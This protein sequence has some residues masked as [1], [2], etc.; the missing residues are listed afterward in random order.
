MSCVFTTG[1][2]DGGSDD[3][4]DPAALP[5][6]G[7]WIFDV[8]PSVS[9]VLPADDL[10]HSTSPVVIVFSES[11]AQSTLA[12]AVELVPIFNG[13]PGTALPGVAQALVGDGRV[14]VLL[15]T[16]LAPADYEVRLSTSAVVT[17]LTGQR[18]VEAPGALLS[19]FTVPATAPTE[20]RVVATWPVDAATAQSTT[21][22]VVVVLDRA[23][24]A[25]SVDDSSFIV[26]VNGADPAADPTAEALVVTVAGI[27]ISD[28]RVYLWR[29]E[30]DEGVPVSLGT[31]ASVELTLS[32]PGSEIVDAT[33][34]ALPETSISFTTLSLAAPL[35]AAFLSTP[36]DGI[37]IRNLTAGDAEE[38]LVQVE[39]DAAAEGDRL[40]LFLVGSSVASPD[41]PSQLVALLRTLTL[42]GTSPIVTADFTL[43]DIDL[44]RTT[45]PA[46][47][48]RFEDGGVAFA[49]R[50]RRGSLVT[51]LAVLDA[52]PGAEGIQDPTLD[53]VAPTLISYL[54]PS[55]ST[56]EAR[57]AVRDMVIAGRASEFLRSVEVSSS[58]GTNGTLPPVIGSD[59]TGSFVAFPIVA[60]VLPPGAVDFSIIGYDAALNASAPQDG[61]FTQLGAVGSGALNP[62]G[63]IMVQVFDAESLELLAGAHVL[64]HAD[65]GDGTSFP[66]LDEAATD[67]L[68]EASL[69]GH[70]PTQA[71]TLL[72]VELSGY[73][74][75]T[76]HGVPATRVSVPL[77]RQ[78][79]GADASVSGTLTTE[80]AIAQLT[81][82][83]GLDRKLDD[84]R[85][86]EET[87][88]TYDG[89]TCSG[90]PLGGSFACP[91]G[92]EPIRI[93]VLGVQSFLAGSLNQAEGS[94]SAAILLQAFDLQIPVPVAD[95]GAATLTSIEL[96]GLFGEPGLF[97]EEDQPFAL[98][99]AE[100]LVD[101]SGG[102]DF[103]NLDDDPDSTGTPRVSVETIVPG[104]PGTV[105]V[106]L[107]LAFE[108]VP[109][110]PF[111][112]VKSAVPGAVGIDGFF[113]LNGLVDTDFRV[114]ME[115]RDGD[116][117]RAGVRVRRSALASHAAPNLPELLSP[118]SGGNSL[119]TSYSVVFENTILDGAGEPGLYEVVL[120][121][122]VGRRWH[123]WRGD[124]VDGGDLSVRVPDLGGTAAIGLASGATSCTIA[125][126]AWQSLSPSEFLWSDIER[127]HDL[128]AATKSVSFTVP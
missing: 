3:L 40:D 106:G 36:S 98:E 54:H 97:A 62:G 45:D 68:G 73:D 74:L 9:E 93:G 82:L 128:F 2:L 103:A 44:L 23:A 52:D 46:L 33:G 126:F 85:R 7:Q 29:S 26:Q 41:V 35:A 72:S 5:E 91:Y 24:A 114:R 15:P 81:F 99:D 63:V 71:G 92:P 108:V 111:W 20:P 37:G 61:T 32:P 8:R 16:I 10:V 125:A 11:I 113:G 118:P 51:P 6:D 30:D 101:P 60:G 117:A 102:I 94:F 39:L 121:D 67:A 89:G 49:F 14:L 112:N 58:L 90:G 78:G 64:T 80:S 48:A 76:F 83:A 79:S 12:S 116:G 95:A 107:G 28:T 75:F 77:V 4:G 22:E 70:G 59:P 120:T 122:A 47:E 25:A 65:V 109:G 27:T 115:V 127:E 100:F 69:A 84:S 43:A 31:S 1:C 66:L 13:V 55:G 21:G 56:T 105:T 17:D 87:A 18:L 57:S 38:L 119:S 88:A 50:L 53:T 110:V 123:L 42:A 104:I 34:T 124:D 96:L 19:S 86:A